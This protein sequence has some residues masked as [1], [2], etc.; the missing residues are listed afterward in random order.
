MALTNHTTPLLS[1]VLSPRMTS[2]RSIFKTRD[3][4]G[5]PDNAV[6]TAAL[7]SRTV[8]DAYGI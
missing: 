3:L 1:D 2:T 6:A 7:A 5:M 4:L 8:M